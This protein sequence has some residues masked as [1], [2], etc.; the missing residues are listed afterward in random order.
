ML[1]RR[2]PFEFF[3]AVPSCRLGDKLSRQAAAP[4]WDA[5][6]RYN[7]DEH[8]GINARHRVKTAALIWRNWEI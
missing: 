5:L 4:R 7:R 3:M 6:Q 8:Q 1:Q 2:F